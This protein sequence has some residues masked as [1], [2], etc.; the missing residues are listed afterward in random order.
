MATADRVRQMLGGLQE[1]ARRVNRYF[2]LGPSGYIWLGVVSLAVLVAIVAVTSYLRRRARLRAVVGRVP[3]GVVR[4]IGFYVDLLQAFER[5]G[6]PKPSHM[7][8]RRHLRDL[9]EVRP[10]LAKA[11][12]PLVDLF[13]EIRFG[14][15]RP[16]AEI[17]R[18]AAQ[19]AR[20]MLELAGET[21][22]GSG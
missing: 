10:D 9:A 22:E 12:A 11:A 18:S 3:R 5:A 20:R 13:Y 2:R 21:P 19:E 17:R 8:P 7:T 15:L 4:E 1:I 6:C 16:D 14:D